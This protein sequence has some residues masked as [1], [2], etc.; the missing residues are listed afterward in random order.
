MP[1]GRAPAGEAAAEDPRL[2]SINE[3][4][5]GEDRPWTAHPTFPPPSRR[6]HRRRPGR[7]RRRGPSG[8]ARPGLRPVRKWPGAGRGDAASGAMSPSSRR[9]ATSST[10]RRAQLLEAD[11]LVDARS[12][13]RSD[14][15]RADR[16]Y[17]APLAA[18]P[19]IAPHLRF[20]ARVVSVTRRGMDRVP[21]T[22]R[23]T[24]PF[25]IVTVGADGRESRVTWRV[26][27]LMRRARGA[28]RIRPA[29]AACRPRANGPLRRASATAFPTCSA[30]R[31]RDSPA[32]A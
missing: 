22:G 17:L 15:S 23:E 6:D 19:A 7:P 14:G 16:R 20:D 26:R 2:T 27:S 4:S 3:Q 31:R 9:G 28:D 32:S 30:P 24:R 1:P 8:D 25:E 11:R 13:P 5:H 12:R 29:P 18:H 10:R 21:S